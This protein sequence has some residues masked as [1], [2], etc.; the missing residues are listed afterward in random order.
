[1]TLGRA[2]ALLAL[3]VGAPARVSADRP[4]RGECSERVARLGAAFARAESRP[5]DAVPLPAA[6][7]L[8]ALVAP[9]APPPEGLTAIVERT[10]TELLV[11]GRAV[12]GGSSASELAAAV[13]REIESAERR[14]T[15]LHDGEPAPRPQLG[16]WIDGTR[17]ARETV[18]LLAAL[19][20]R[21]EV[22]LLAVAR[23]PPPPSIPPRISGR[24]DAIRAETD[25][26][27]KFPLVARAAAEALG[28]C[29]PDGPLP[30]DAEAGVEERERRVHGAI[31]RAVTACSCA[32]VDVEMLEALATGL[33]VRSPVYLGPIEIRPRARVRVT[34]AGTATTQ[35]LVDR[36]PAGARQVA[37]TWAR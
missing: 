15:L 21:Y 35:D 7:G 12:E 32:G 22:G 19:G 34:L 36:L 37:V 31:L 9:A 20:E 26:A 23:A 4:P 29:R 30:D 28:A 17:P 10:G 14:W 1:V 11:D 24:L 8:E 16:L 27:G 3:V 18:A 2:A 13:A 33:D 6:R 5:P 25:P